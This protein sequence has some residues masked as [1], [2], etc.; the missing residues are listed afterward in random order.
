L[1][2]CDPEQKLGFGYV[3]NNMH[4]GQWLIDPRARALV[5]AVYEA[6]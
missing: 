2:Y 1:G 5:A 3:M 6:L 4:M